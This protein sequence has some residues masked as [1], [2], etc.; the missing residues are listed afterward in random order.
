MENVIQKKIS[1]FLS[2]HQRRRYSAASEYFIKGGNVFFKNYLNE[3]QQSS[4]SKH[5]KKWLEKKIQQERQDLQ[6]LNEHEQE[7]KKGQSILDEL[8]ILGISIF[9][10]YLFFKKQV[11]SFVTKIKPHFE[12]FYT[13]TTS[14]GKTL[15]SHINKILD[16][17]KIFDTL[18]Q[19]MSISW[20][21]V[22]SFVSSVWNYVAL[23]F[24]QFLNG[25]N[26]I[27][28]ENVF[29]II[30]KEITSN[31]ASAIV[32][33]ETLG[34][35]LSLFGA[36][37]DN[38]LQIQLYPNLTRYIRFGED[39]MKN[40]RDVLI[41]INQGL[42][43]APG[44][45]TYV[46]SGMFTIGGNLNPG[47]TDPNAVFLYSE[48]SEPPKNNIQGGI[49]R[50]YDIP[51]NIWNNKMDDK[52][53]IVDGVGSIVKKFL[54]SS[55]DVYP[56]QYID[57]IGT[58][59]LSGYIP[60]PFGQSW[61]NLLNAWD[62]IKDTHTGEKRD[63]TSIK[64]WERRYSGDKKIFGIFETMHEKIKKHGPKIYNWYPTY[65]DEYNNLK[66]RI[67]VAPV[68]SRYIKK[69]D[70]SYYEH[71]YDPYKVFNVGDMGRLLYLSSVTGVILYRLQRDES[72]QRQLDKHNSG[73]VSRIE[74]GDEKTLLYGSM[75]YGVVQK[76]SDYIV[77]SKSDILVASDMLSSGALKSVDYFK[78]VEGI[79]LSIVNG[80]E[81][82][83][84]LEVLPLKYDTYDYNIIIDYIKTINDIISGTFRNWLKPQLSGSKHVKGVVVNSSSDGK[85]AYVGDV[86]TY[87][88]KDYYSNR[89]SD[90]ILY[91]EE[92]DTKNHVTSV[93][94]C[95]SIIDEHVMLKKRQMRI[96]Q[97]RKEALEMFNNNIKELQNK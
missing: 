94:L 58:N 91:K 32:N 93:S 45:Q 90:A 78:R 18:W 24:D 3:I 66:T 22:T 68:E 15:I 44:V 7:Y 80:N 41:A 70:M 25:K 63:G 39:V 13:L 8:S 69:G 26:K 76:L 51:P 84:G 67:N 59:Q 55:I 71:L 83:L 47:Y 62:S 4:S 43:G 77:D 86:S 64:L 20:E 14:T 5:V 82:F 61:V 17:Y 12:K 50:N 60:S 56:V 10:G 54:T 27:Y 72:L 19:V 40:M 36:K 31:V 37:F 42:K 9:A 34:T 6:S 30:F 28:G 75:L 1:S 35:A 2:S 81:L 49:I 87:V 23:G 74:N 21:K 97:R 79:L 16:Q 57:K 95:N 85:I 53:Y 38:A 11:D 29:V 33:T 52:G 96:Y 48:F 73:I 92:V 88:V 65:L 89:T 46:A